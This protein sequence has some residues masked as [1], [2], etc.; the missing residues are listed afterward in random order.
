MPVPPAPSSPASGVHL[1]PGRPPVLLAEPTGDAA[2]WAAGYRD[3]LRSLVAEYGAVL[4][5]GLGLRDADQAGAV[6]RHLATGLLTEKEAFAPRR[7]YAD[8]VYSSTKWPAGQPMCMHHELS[9][10]LT[11]P[12]LLLFACLTAPDSGG[13]TALADAP[14]VLD[15]LPAELAE[16]FEREGWLLTRSYNDEVGATF[17]EAFGT[18]DRRAVERYCRGHAID[19]AWQPGG[20][21]RTRQRR[22]AVVRHPV[23]GRRCWFNQIAFLNEWTMEPE[24]REYLVDVYGADALPF[25]TRYGGG[26]PIGED[27]VRLLNTVY[28]AHTTREPW[29]AGDLMLVDNVRTAHSRE[30]YEGPR[31]VLVA[32]T[33]AVLLTACR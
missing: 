30:P 28:E 23:S 16:R 5:R 14:T 8:G 3:T 4:V 26:D 10:T 18:D 6:F 15:A 13:A 25:N 19:F 33:D 20:G 9:Y 27:V 31:D 12:G 17:A 7:E 1:L 11:A 32:M 29:Q 21:L 22:S 2:G 24:V